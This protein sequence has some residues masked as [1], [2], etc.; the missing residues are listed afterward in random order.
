ME[1]LDLARL[2]KRIVKT[3]STEEALKNAVP[4]EWP[5]DV[6][7]GSKKVLISSGEP[8]KDGNA[9]YGVKMKYV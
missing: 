5:S 8:A 1:K 2:K 6:V 4:I 3:I 7:N 9:K